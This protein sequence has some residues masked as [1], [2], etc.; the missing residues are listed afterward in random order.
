MKEGGGNEGEQRRRKRRGE[1]GEE[2]TPWPQEL[3]SGEGKV[4]CQ[5]T[6]RTSLKEFVKEQLGPYCC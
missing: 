2:E 6:Q 4:W 3:R 5:A 1:E